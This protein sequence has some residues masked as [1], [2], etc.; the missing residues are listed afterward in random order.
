MNKRKPYP[1]ETADEYARR[2]KI[3]LHEAKRI[4]NRTTH[5]DQEDGDE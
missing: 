1:N 3:P 5:D 4:V 2:L